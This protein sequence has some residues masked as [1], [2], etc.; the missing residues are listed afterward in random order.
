[1]TD[2]TVTWTAIITPVLVFQGIKKRRSREGDL[3]ADSQT[4]QSPLKQGIAIYD[5][6]NVILCMIRRPC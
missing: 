5:I 3:G 2:E 1:M 4:P 6:P